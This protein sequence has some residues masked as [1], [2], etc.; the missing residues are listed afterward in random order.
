M[1]LLEGDIFN[2]NEF[3]EK[4]LVKLIYRDLHNLRQQFEEYKRDNTTQKDIAELQKH[5]F[6]LR[7]ELELQK[8]LREEAEKKNKNLV[9]WVAV[10]L[11][12]FQVALKFLFRNGN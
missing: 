5:V 2:P 11:A 9:A 4:E 1:S 10:I 12:A 6:Q 7:A 3:T 8:S